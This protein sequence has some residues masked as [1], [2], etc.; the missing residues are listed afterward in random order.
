MAIKSKKVRVRFLQKMHMNLFNH[1]SVCSYFQI[2]RL[3]IFIS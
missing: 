2:S 1:K 3:E